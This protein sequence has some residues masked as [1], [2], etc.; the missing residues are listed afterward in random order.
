[1]SSASPAPPAALPIRVSC[2]WRASGG[3]RAAAPRRPRSG[4]LPGRDARPSR[5]RQEDNLH[6]VGEPVTQFHL[7]R[8]DSVALVTMD[9][10]TRA[11][12]PNI[13]GR[14][15]L[16][17]LARL[18][19]ELE[20]SRLHGPRHHRQAGELLRR[21]RPR[22]VPAHRDPRARDRGQPRGT[23]PLHTHPQASVPDG[24]RDQRRRPRRGRRARAAL[25]LPRD[26][27]RG[28]ARRVARMPARH[29]PG[30]GRDAARTAADRPRG[31]READ[32][33]ATRCARTRCWTRSRRTSSASSIA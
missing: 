33:H 6:S 25:R 1:M 15:A 5:T 11:G 21:R 24:G 22:R 14:G 4:R 31:G 2:R 32:G 18:L 30:L 7:D 13:L 9:D 20:E 29:R 10:G 19:P 26:R 17:S 8:R 28:P 3:R 12:R 16:E 27:R 23:R